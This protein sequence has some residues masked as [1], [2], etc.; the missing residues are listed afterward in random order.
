MMRK[1]K[2]WW[3]SLDRW[4]LFLFSLGVVSINGRNQ[5]RILGIG[6]V[7][8]CIYKYATA[9][10]KWKNYDH[11]PE[12]FA[13][14]L[15]GV[16][17]GL[18]GVMVCASIPL[19][20][21]NY[22]ILLQNIM[23]IWSVYVLL[24]LTWSDR[25]VYWAIIIGCIVQM[26]AVRMGI[27]VEKDVGMIIGEEVFGEERVSGLT[28]N[29]NSLGFTMVTGFYCL[30]QVWQMKRSP[31]NFILKV[32]L[33]G[34]MMASVYITWQTGSRKTSTAMI[35]L[36]IGWLVWVLPQ[37]KG[38]SAL[39]MRVGVLAAMLVVGGALLAFISD[40]TMVGK[41]FKML[42][43]QGQGS[44]VVGLEDDIRADMYKEGIMMVLAH[45]IAGVGLGHF[46]YYYWAGA[47]SHS[48]YIEP[49]SCTGLVGFLLYHSFNGFLL[50]RV[51]RLRRRV[52][53]NNDKYILNAILLSL[54]VHFLLGLGAPYWCG[55]RSA[56]L[57]TTFVTYTWMLERRLKLG[58]VSD[59]RWGF[60]N[61][62]NV[63]NGMPRIG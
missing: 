52:R 40:E 61:E 47:Y 35:V 44:V 56:M 55:Q 12:L 8:A 57:L 33:I 63:S 30:M 1:E 24:R 62:G 22:R 34:F 41:R 15:W 38:S 50:M 10:T 3:L 21:A 2:P 17:A 29:A 53:N 27:S 23:M 49:L 60:G 54:C 19:F 11:P 13:Y 7:L 9:N 16:W 18:T 14:T 5:L 31:I 26:V 36:I 28:G 58:I 39:F 4:A 48:D 51:L 46:E 20:W 43:E 59:Q 42:L 32:L 6:L 37:G 45:P 25:L